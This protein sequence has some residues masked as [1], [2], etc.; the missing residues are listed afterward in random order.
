MPSS[1]SRYLTRNSDTISQIHIKH[2][3]FKNSFFSSTI[4]EWNNLDPDIRNSEDVGVIKSKILKFIR[5]KPNSIYNCY[6]SKG[7]GLVTRLWIGLS[8]LCEHK[9]KH[10]FQDCLNSLCLCRN[11]I[12]TSSHFLLHCPTYSNKMIFLN[13]IRNI[14]YGILELSDTIMI[15]TLLFGDSLFSVSTNTN[16]Y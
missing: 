10:S 13:K 16:S 15:K 2:N 14:N 1:T 5:P 3:F 12:E 4:N 6:N 7:N 9:F 11:D 8:H